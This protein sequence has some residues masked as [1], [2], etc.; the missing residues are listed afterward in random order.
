MTGF[1]PFFNPA[2]GEW[3]EFTAVAGDSDGQLVRF[4]WRSMPG[5][6][7]TE[8]IHPGQEER[9]IITSGEARFTLDGEELK[10]RAGET[11]VVPAGVRH[12]EETPDR[13]DPGHRAWSSGRRCAPGSST[14]PSPAWSPTA[15]PRS[16]AR[17]ATRSSSAPPSGISA[18][19]AGATTPPIA[20]QNIM[21]PPLWAAA[22]A[23]GVRPYYTRWTAG[24]GS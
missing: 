19:K 20:V 15:G 16:G 21:L 5:G 1:R 3:I 4:S 24:C 7:I 22:K 9:F 14:R 11:V 23:F 6:L 10:A 17:R 8:H 12:S 13:R 18:T 2:T